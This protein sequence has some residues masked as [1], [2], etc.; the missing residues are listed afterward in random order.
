MASSDRGTFSK[1]AVP[2]AEDPIDLTGAVP[3]GAAL[4]QPPAHL[5]RRRRASNAA[6]P[7]VARQPQPQ[8]KRRYRESGFVSTEGQDLVRLI[9]NHQQGR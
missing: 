4:G 9:R 5:C 7:P 1:A 6:P 2:T 3:T 8:N